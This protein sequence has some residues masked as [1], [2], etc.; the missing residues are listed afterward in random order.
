[1]KEKIEQLLIS[2]IESGDIPSASYLV[3]KR[4]EI[5]ASGAVGRAVVTPDE[6]LAEP[7]TIYDLASLT[8]PLVTGLLSAIFIERGLFSMDHRASV[9]LT[10]LEAAGKRMITVGEL[11]THSSHL[12]AWLPLYLLADTP[13]DVLRVI[14]N[15]PVEYGADTVVYSDLNYIVL[16]AILASISRMPLDA[17]AKAELFE[18]LGLRNTF[19]NPAPE[20]KSRIAASENGNAFEKQTCEEQG[21][22]VGKH[23]LRFR[24]NPIWGSVH[25]GNA[26]F[27]GG[28]A[29]HAGLFSNAE[30][31]LKLALQ[32]LP[33]TTTLLKPETCELFRTNFTPETNEHR[34]L[35][36]Q[37]ASTPE[38]TAGRHLS[39]DSFGHLGF[40]GT[41]LWIDP[42]SERVYILLTNRTHNRELPFA[43]INSLRREFHEIAAGKS[44]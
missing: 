11:L 30:N 24:H 26:W 33:A 21:F 38:S 13:D 41:S 27:M 15:V 42:S 3:S 25:D 22:D 44:I 37:L 7:Q 12:P 1:V 39:G 5:L 17:L 18:P 6:V 19:F 40:T 20:L 31:V 34:S 36:F 9:L 29:G 14:S 28:V 4:G 23:P 16:G 10:D 32:F 35:G 43:N 8:K 2:S